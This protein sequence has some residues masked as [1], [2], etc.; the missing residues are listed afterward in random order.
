[1]MGEKTFSGALDVLKSKG[2][3]MHLDSSTIEGGKHAFFLF[4]NRGELRG[5]SL[6]KPLRGASRRISLTSNVLQAL[7]TFEDWIIDT[8]WSVAS[9][10][11]IKY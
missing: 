7:A 10:V 4:L 1:M 6:I 8:S 2:G 11:D 9:G 3:R 5:H